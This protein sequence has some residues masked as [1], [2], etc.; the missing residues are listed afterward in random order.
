ML[1][2]HS[3]RHV[4]ALALRVARGALIGY[5][6]AGAALYAFQ[7]QVLLQPG[8]PGVEHGQA[9]HIPDGYLGSV[10]EPT[11][12]PRATVVVF[13][14]NAGTVSDRAYMAAPLTALGYRVVLVEYPGYGHRAGELRIA[15]LGERGVEDFDRVR[16]RYPK[17]PIAVLGESLGAAMAA[18]VAAARPAAVCNLVLITPW[19]RLSE[20]AQEKFPI[21]PA[22]LMLKADYPS[23]LALQRYTGPVTIVGAERDQVI[24]VRHAKTLADSRPDARWELRPGVGHN[25]WPASAKLEDWQR[26]LSGG[27]AWPVS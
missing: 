3:F 17:E 5:L 12:A 15:E 9:L 21:F 16:A 25:D 7:D 2:T 22:R 19:N 6:L 27:C 13:H 1:T 11:T 14:G 24:P 10:L 18:T 20:V 26:W 4:P 23:D 8:P